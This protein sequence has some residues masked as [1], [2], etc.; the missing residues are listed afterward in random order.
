LRSPPFTTWLPAEFMHYPI[1][2]PLDWFNIL[3]LGTTLLEL[4]L[5]YASFVNRR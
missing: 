5:C 4:E 3:L 2:L 1:A